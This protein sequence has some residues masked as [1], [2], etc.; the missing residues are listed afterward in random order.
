MKETDVV[1]MVTFV[2]YIAGVF[3]LAAL[4]HRLLSKKSFMGEYFLGSRG[5]GSWALAFTFAATSASGGSFT[6]FPSF[7]YSYGW[8]LA[9]WIA[10]YMIVPVCTMGVLGKRL[11]QVARK[12]GA[13][14]I[15][16]VL[17]DRYLS[18]TLGIF[19]SC[20]IIFFMTCNLV[21]QFKAGAIILETVFKISSWNLQGV[22]AGESFLVGLILF[23]IIVVVYTAYGGFRAVVWTDVMQGIVMGLG[24]ML[25]VPIVI[26]MAGGMKQVSE[27]LKN[28]PPRAMTFLDKAENNDLAIELTTQERTNEVPLGVLFPIPDAS[29][30]KDK[31]VVE[32][33]PDAKNKDRWWIQ[34]KFA[35]DKA[36]KPTSTGKDIKQALEQSDPEIRK[37]IRVRYPRNNDGTGTWEK[38]PDDDKSKPLKYPFIYGDEFIFGPGRTNTGDP[39][40]TFGFVISFFFMWS[41]SGMGQPGTMVRLMAFK[42]SGTLRRSIITVTIYYSLIYLPL[43]FVFVAGRTLLEQPLAPQDS[44]SAMATLAIDVVGSQGLFYAILG[45]IMVAAP[46]SAVMSTVDSFLLVTSSSCVRDIYQRSIDPEVSEKAIKYGSY[47]TTVIIGV[48]VTLLTAPEPQFLQKII[49]FT[50]GGFAA[51][52][53]APVFLGLYWKGMTR[54]GALTSMIGGFLLMLTLT[55]PSMLG[56]KTINLLGMH[57]IFWGLFGSFAAGIVVSKL[58]GPPPKDLIDFYF[59]RPV[60][61]ES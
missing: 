49:V 14:T 42:E 18:P 45:A 21:A 34:V 28:Q 13:I 3:V 35:V 15:P 51:T 2:A 33:V 37:W 54:A 25:L 19:A 26:S 32:R 30:P 56:G 52:F 41:I 5:L 36:G 31:P 48:I 4:S 29:F 9:L 55:V 53:L 61:K 47:A 6:G 59:R 16:D 8:V 44:D 11:N 39:F 22:L 58:T 10:S 38:V 46:F 57:P 60:Q 12:Q 23:A 20:T 7:V 40:H 43:V 17:R 1:T 50:G 24:V 27:K